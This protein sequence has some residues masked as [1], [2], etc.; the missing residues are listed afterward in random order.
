MKEEAPEKPESKVEPAA[1]LA[2]EGSGG[3]RQDIISIQVNGSSVSIHRGHQTVVAIKQAAHVP[4]ADALEQIVD[5]RLVPLDDNGA[6]TL[7]GDEMFVSHVRDC[8][9]S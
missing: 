5:G 2:G 3:H 9:A 8:G 6:V 7:K 1:G 4:L